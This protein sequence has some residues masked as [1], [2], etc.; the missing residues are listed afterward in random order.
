[1]S[2]ID[3]GVGTFGILCSFKLKLLWNVHCGQQSQEMA[4]VKNRCEASIVHCYYALLCALCYLC[5][6]TDVN[7]CA[8]TNPCSNGGTCVNDYGKYFCRCSRGFAGYNCDRRKH[9]PLR[10]HKLTKKLL[11]V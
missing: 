2:A 11:L 8:A 4:I 10:H 7:E 3:L 6:S 5:L 1:M 9:L